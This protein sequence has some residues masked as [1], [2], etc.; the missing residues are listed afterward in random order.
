[1]LAHQGRRREAQARNGTWPSRRPGAERDKRHEGPGG[2]DLGPDATK[3]PAKTTWDPTPRRPRRRRPGAERDKRHEDPDGDDLR[4]NATNATKGPAETPCGRT[5]RKGP[6]ETTCGRTRRRARRG[7][8]QA[9]RIR[10][11]VQWGGLPAE[12]LDTSMAD[13]SAI[14]QAV[15][16]FSY[17]LYYRWE[18]SGLSLRRL[19]TGP[20]APGGSAG[21]PAGPPPPPAGAPTPAPARRRPAT[22]A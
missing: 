20:A 11:P 21:R 5:R 3:A 1:M 8:S 16:E 17:H 9:L 10:L 19:P 15:L 2:D 7:G 13:R 14:W 18:P 6:A 12:A 22:A 4:P